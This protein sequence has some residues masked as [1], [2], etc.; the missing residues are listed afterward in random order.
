M[1]AQVVTM[2]Q[3]SSTTMLPMFVAMK[4]QMLPP[5]QPGDECDDQAKDDGQAGC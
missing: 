5:L 4:V 3:V 1:I 2:C